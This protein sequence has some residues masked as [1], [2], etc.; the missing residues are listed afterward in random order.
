[1]ESRAL[2][3]RPNHRDLDRLQTHPAG[4]EKNL[5][6]KPPALDPLQGKN[7]LRR[8]TSKGF[9]AALR[10]PEMQTQN[11][12]QQHVKNASERL[13]VEGLALGLEFGAQPA[14][15]Y[16]DVGPLMDSIEQFLRFGDRRG[17]VG[18]C[19]QT[20][21]TASV[22]HA[23]AHAISLAT[24]SRVLHEL[25]LRVGAGVFTNDRRSI[26]ARAV[27]HHQDLGIPFLFSGVAEDF[28]ERGANAAAFVVG[29]DDE[30]VGQG[31]SQFSVLSSRFP[32]LSSWTNINSWPLLR[33]ENWE[34]GTE[35]R[36]LAAL[37]EHAEKFG[38]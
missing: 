2:T 27:V 5:W 30:A 8:L 13:P 15:S 33:T 4:Q 18:V 9:E 10:I 21:I 29:G 14:G 1:M 19:K 34:L 12:P 11:E 32:L 3:V 35:L 37:V 20:N 26:V 16:G 25:N 23:V 6:I 28:I 38:D 24:V 7:S 31:S 36:D 17:E 22:Q